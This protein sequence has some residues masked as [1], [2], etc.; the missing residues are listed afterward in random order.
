MQSIC[1]YL[2]AKTSNNHHLSDAATLLGHAIANAGY[3][4]VYGGSS[5]GLMGILA[6]AV[7]ARG[8]VV[9]GVIPQQ[10]IDQEKPLNTLDELLVTHSMQERKLLMEQRADG[11]IVMPGGLGTLEEAFETWNAI[12]LGILKKPIGF[13]NI[14]GF[15]DDLFSFIETCVHHGFVSLAQANR[16]KRHT[17]PQ[18]LLTELMQHERFIKQDALA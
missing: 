11:F 14:D 2:G 10:L 12:K 17:D 13:L 5:Q 7:M 18:L 16:P 1:V 15:F 3:R 6:H 9:T 4:L 8:G